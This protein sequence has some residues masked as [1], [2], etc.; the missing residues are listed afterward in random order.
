MRFC[1]LLLVILLELALGD[2]AFA[3][4]RV[5]LVIGNFDYRFAPR[6]INTQNDSRAMASLLREEGFEVDEHSNLANADLRQAIR[7]FFAKTQDADVAVVFYAGHGLEVDGVNYVVPVD[8]K[9]R[10]D[11]DVED[12][13]V[14]LDRIMQVLEPA[15]RLR[16]VILDACRDNPFLASMKRTVMTRAVARGLAK[17]EPSKP[18]TLV[19]FAAKAGSVAEDGQ[20][21][22]SPFTKALLK[23]IAEPGLDIRLALGRVRDDVIETTKHSQ[24][25]FVYGSLGG[26]V[27]T[28]SIKLA[29]EI[30]QD[31]DDARKDFDIARQLATVDAWDA[32]LARHT[33]GYVAEMARKERERLA[34]LQSG[35]PASSGKTQPDEEPKLLTFEQADRKRVAE[36]GAPQAAAAGV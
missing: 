18:N 22:H 14:S 30:K 3:A 34:A 7:S 12:E 25:P 35:V 26:S 9:L 23:H 4:R 8:A 11:I 31:G 2:A 20:G 29:V 28:L 15:R 19:A 10:A 27:I 1:T 33:Q 21:T 32:F 36:I 5:A 6:L 13:A 24:E 16:L 17:V